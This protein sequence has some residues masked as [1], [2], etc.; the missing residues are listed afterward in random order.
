M[1]ARKDR[2]FLTPNWHV[3]CRLVAELP[4]DAVVGMR[5]LTWA[6]PSAIALIALLFT[7][8]YGYTDLNLRQQIDEG[9]RAMEDTYWDVAEVRRMQRF[10]EI[11]AKKIESAYND[12]KTPILISGF[13]VDMGH[14][15]PD[16]MIVD[17]IEFGDGR[18]N[19]KGRFQ[20]TPEHASQIL[21][22]YIDK[23]RKEPAIGAHFSSI[24][25][26]GLERSTENE[27]MMIYEVTF[28]IKPRS[29]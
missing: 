20:E 1:S 22:G 12:I 28:R 26:I 4:E 14:T 9:N 11:E 29:L 17:S 13:M 27:Q 15:M 6:V 23:L 19:V 2:L 7:G 24:N 18:I 25:I 5:F 3:D 10:Y 8:W 16:R 21:G